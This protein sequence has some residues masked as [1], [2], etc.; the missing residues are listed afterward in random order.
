MGDGVKRERTRR[1]SCWSRRGEGEAGRTQTLP[2]VK[3]RRGLK[4]ISVTCTGYSHQT[5]FIIYI[6]N[7]E[8][9]H[10]SSRKE[11]TSASLLK[12]H[13][14]PPFGKG[15]A[16]IYS[17]FTPSSVSNPFG[18]VMSCLFC[19]TVS[20][21]HHVYSDNFTKLKNFQNIFRPLPRLLL[22]LLL[23]RH[24][25]LLLL[26]SSDQSRLRHPLS[27]LGHC[28]QYGDARGVLPDKP[29]CI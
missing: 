2:H 9:N 13:Q 8:L 27:L 20:V 21:V 12:P 28:N 16:D 26:Q 15:D 14:R 10:L 5:T 3:R 4:M 18:L 29:L 19:R 7:T 1:Q 25:R 24:I 22:P 23:Q 17:R 11:A 6:S